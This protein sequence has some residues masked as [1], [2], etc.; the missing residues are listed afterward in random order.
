MRQA[1]LVRPPDLAV[2]ALASLVAVGAIAGGP[3]MIGALGIAVLVLANLVYPIHGVAALLVSG[4]TYLL[5]SPY[6]PKG[7]P[8]SFLLLVL[9]MTGLAFRRVY[10]KR[11]AP[12][13]WHAPDVAA[14][15]LLLNALLYIPLAPNLKIGIYGYHET[16]RLFLLYFVV[17]LLAPG[18]APVRR[19][20]WTVAAIGFAVSLYGCLQPYFHY[21]YIMVKY[22]LVESLRDYAGFDSGRVSR[23][24]SILTSPL[25]LGYVGMVGAL[26]AAAILMIP[27]PH[28]AA[29]WAAPFLLAVSVGASAVSYT[30]S[31]W[32]GIAAGLGAALLSVVRGRG[33]LVLIAA[34]VAFVLAAARFVPKLTEK[35]GQYALTIAS[36]DPSETS[37]H[38]VAL[39][40][41]AR[42]FWDHKLGIGLGTASFSGFQ[43]GNGV[44]F[45]SENTYFQMGIQ[46]G[47]QGMLA[48]IAF[49]VL[50]GLAGL[51]TA[52][53]ATA[54]A[55]H[56]RLGAAVV[57][58]LIGFAVAGIS[59]PT[60]LDVAA[61]GPLWVMAALL[62][63]T[64]DARPAGPPAA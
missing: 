5:I 63:N 28:D 43:H 22:D 4:P 45:W 37:L 3:A 26:A 39:V 12:F 55:G 62:V 31:S 21:D 51:R 11:P 64:K 34:P 25:S 46:T 53:D 9:T 44:Q 17:R 49:L 2:L 32:M 16:L 1:V 24:Y 61:F 35:V 10:E 13:R 36:Q 23:A 14:L 47:F 59:I 38:Y 29:V 56:R 6:V 8:F 54:P 20:L 30:R 18:P 52:R 48:L 60:I 33:R 57:M 19:L 15:V 27:R 7:L 40:A 41:A 42:F 50:A 58:G